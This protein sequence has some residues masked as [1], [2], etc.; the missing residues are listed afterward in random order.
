MAL[1]KAVAEPGEAPTYAALEAALVDAAKPPGESA[2]WDEIE[3][4]LRRLRDGADVYYSGLTGPLL[5]DAC[6]SRRSG[7]TT[8]F[9]VTNGRIV[10][11]VQ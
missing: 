6:G 5:L 2:G 8:G 1:E 3:L 9:H 10:D 4:G 7:V 11:D